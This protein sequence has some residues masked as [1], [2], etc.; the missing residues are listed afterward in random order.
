MKPGFRVEKAGRYRSGVFIFKRLSS[1]PSVDSKYVRNKDEGSWTGRKIIKGKCEK[2][3]AVT[4]LGLPGFSGGV[5]W[6][7]NRRMVV[8]VGQD[9]NRYPVNDNENL[10][11]VEGPPS[12]L[13]CE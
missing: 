11:W 5:S 2:L 12:K 8:T 7:D 4:F 13:C 10:L 6:R 1:R 3:L 9:V